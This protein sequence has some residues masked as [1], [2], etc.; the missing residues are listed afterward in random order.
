MK[1]KCICIDW[2]PKT[3]IS[4][5]SAI[6]ELV[7]KA[8]VAHNRSALE[9]TH[10]CCALRSH[11]FC[12]WRAFGDA[13]FY[14]HNS[15]CYDCSGRQPGMQR[16]Y[17]GFKINAQVGPSFK[18]VRKE[19]KHLTVKGDFRFMNPFPSESHACAA[20]TTV[21]IIWPIQFGH[22]IREL[23][24]QNKTKPP[25]DN[26]VLWRGTTALTAVGNDTGTIS[27]DMFTQGW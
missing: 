2:F 6:R 16:D 26:D 3:F 24:K 5:K 1:N 10:I 7:T 23:Q 20:L 4:L 9:V 15:R 25:K 11:N 21:L 17:L 27:R 14:P 22:P 18:Q 13:L 12:F 8:Q 19:V